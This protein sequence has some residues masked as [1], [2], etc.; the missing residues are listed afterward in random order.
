[1]INKTNFGIKLSCRWWLD[2]FS[3]ALWRMISYQK[4]H[5]K[6]ITELWSIHPLQTYYGL[7][8]LH[9][10]IAINLQNR[11][12][13]F[14]HIWGK[15][16]QAWG[17][18]K[19]QALCSSLFAQNMQKEKITPILQAPQ[20]FARPPRVWNTSRSS[21]FSASFSHLDVLWLCLQQRW[22]FLPLLSM[23]C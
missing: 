16:R 18:R 10:Y 20:L 9:C 13:M 21:F 14:L 17:K 3:I 11:Q 4:I 1:M 12:K 2:E 5:G 22:S 15:Q 23:L 7:C 8:W 19:V 6:S